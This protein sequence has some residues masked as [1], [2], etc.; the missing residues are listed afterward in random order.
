MSGNCSDFEN[1]SLRIQ[2]T[3]SWH[4]KL[5]HLQWYRQLHISTSSGAM[6]VSFRA[7]CNSGLLKTGLM[8]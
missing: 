3:Q 1:S 2:A 8:S 4:A 7:Q 6:N 5:S